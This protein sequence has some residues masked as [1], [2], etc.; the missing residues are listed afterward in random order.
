MLI[1]RKHSIKICCYNHYL[2]DVQRVLK[3]MVRI[4][5]LKWVLEFTTYQH[6]SLLQPVRYEWCS[7]LHSG[8]FNSKGNS[9]DYHTGKGSTTWWSSMACCIFSSA[10]NEGEYDN[11]KDISCLVNIWERIL[12]RSLHVKSKTV[13]WISN[14]SVSHSI[15]KNDF[16]GRL[17]YD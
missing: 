4:E 14:H 15:L 12:Q 13:I 8:T 5:F 7:S 2:S 6:F 3:S 10:P 11:V 1:D 9:V 16:L 17:R